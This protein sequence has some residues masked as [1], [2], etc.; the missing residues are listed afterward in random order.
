MPDEYAGLQ[1]MR[2]VYCSIDVFPYASAVP[3]KI[4]RRLPYAEQVVIRGYRER[5]SAGFFQ[6]SLW[7]S[8]RVL[9]LD[10]GGMNRP[11]FPALFQ[12]F[13]VRSVRFL[14]RG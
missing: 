12:E 1:R 14:G 3:F 7:S 5:F 11:G 13:Q 8:L 9:A 6:A 2:E 4:I 10:A